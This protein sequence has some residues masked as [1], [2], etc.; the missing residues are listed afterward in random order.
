MELQL[1]AM[2]LQIIK[3]SLREFRLAGLGRKQAYLAFVLN[4]F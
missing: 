2:E 3:F 4:K 1:Q